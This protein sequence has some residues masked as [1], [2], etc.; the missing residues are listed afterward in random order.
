MKFLQLGDSELRVSAVGLGCGSFGGLGAMPELI[1]L[2]ESEREARAALDGAYE[3]G[4]TLLDTANSYG[5]GASEEWIGRWL[6][7]RPGV[8]DD[9]VITTKVGCPVGPGGGDRGLS[10]AHIRGQLEVS[11]RRLGTDRID[12]YLTH[13]P[14]PWTPIEETL[15]V[16]GELVRAGT[17][18]HYGLANVDRME[19]AKAVDAADAAGLP[20]PVNVQTGHNLLEPADPRLLAACAERGIGVSAFS[21]LSGGWLAGAYRAGGPYPPLSRMTVLPDR[22]AAVERLAAHGVLG[23]LAAEADRRGTS[24]P[25]LALAWLLSEGTVAL[26]GPATPEQL[27]PAVAAADLDLDPADRAAITAIVDSYR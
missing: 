21:A 14:D 17:I 22:Y 1:G 23:A 4:I 8:R 11:L 7:D 27:D 13:E 9:L 15:A 5:G 24:L 12:L 19:L 18:R 3:R 2:G 16:F 25:T 6:R 10:G 26:V 20:R